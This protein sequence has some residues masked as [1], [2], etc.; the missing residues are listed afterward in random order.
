M[1]INGQS[2]GKRIYTPFLFDITD[3]IKKGMNQ[4]TIRVTPSLYNEFVKRGKDK[5]R[6]FK[7]FKDSTLASEGLAGPVKIFK[8]NN[9][10]KK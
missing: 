9:N 5:Q 8:F 7:M 1:E 4:V 10:N 6:L 2:V 3:Y